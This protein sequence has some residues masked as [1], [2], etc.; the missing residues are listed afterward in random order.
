MT[1][2]ARKHLTHQPD[3]DGVCTRCGFDAQEWRWWRYNTGEGMASKA[4][5][6]I[7]DP[8]GARANAWRRER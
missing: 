2:D 7:C 1:E 6:P 3:E 4:P 8:S 5:A